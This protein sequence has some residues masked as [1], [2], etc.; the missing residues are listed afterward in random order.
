MF[1]KRCS[2]CSRFWV[3][4]KNT[5]RQKQNLCDKCRPSAFWEFVIKTASLSEQNASRPKTAAALARKKMT[6]KLWRQ[7][8]K[9]SAAK[10][11][12]YKK[13]E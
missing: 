5:F 9:C 7:N 10:L 3:D 8:K 6:E 13:K 4:K 11:G 12:N 2:K 1:S